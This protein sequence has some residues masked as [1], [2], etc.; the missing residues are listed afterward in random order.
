[1]A[2]RMT[3]NQMPTQSGAVLASC[4]VA[5]LCSGLLALLAFSL[6]LLLFDGLLDVAFP[7]PPAEKVRHEAPRRELAGTTPAASPG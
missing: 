2:D 1:M 6:M 7:D 5:W 4:P 3:D